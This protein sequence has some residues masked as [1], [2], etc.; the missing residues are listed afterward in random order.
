[1][2]EKNFNLTSIIK[3][4][5]VLTSGVFLAQALQV[6][7]LPL[8]TRLFSASDFAQVAV[9]SSILTLGSMIAT[10]RYHAAIPLPEH[11]EE[12]DSLLLL[13]FCLTIFVVGISFL[14][15]FFLWSLL[16]ATLPLPTHIMWSLLPLAIVL[17]SVFESLQIFLTRVNKYKKIATTKVVRV[18]VCIFVQ[19]TL[20]YFTLTDHGLILGIFAMHLAGALCLTWHYL[21]NRQEKQAHL[22]VQL[23]DLRRIGEK[24]IKYPKY[25]LPETF[26]NYGAVEIGIILIAISTTGP[27]AGY[28]YLVMRVLGIPMMLIGS[29]LSHA[30][31]A[32]A[33]KI[34]DGSELTQVTLRMMSFLALVGL[35]IAI[36]LMLQAP[37]LF[38]F[39]FGPE[40]RDAGK[41]ARWCV[42]W[43]FFQLISSPVS[44]IFHVIGKLGTA[45]IIQA[46]GFFIRLAFLVVGVFLF[47]DYV[48]YIFGVANAIF[49][50]ALIFLIL[51]TLKGLE[52]TD[53]GKAWFDMER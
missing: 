36:I 4:G 45:L 46:L 14:L 15:A 5:F 43:Y 48:I 32:K 9:F 12:A 52:D 50:C 42:V 18:A 51:K 22:D 28:L 2:K 33:A 53:A 8:L 6:I 37:M 7:S 31:Y 17:A 41:I 23:S 34:R 1:M 49:Y 29:S 26:F 27:D 16:D 24:F 39:A 38:A 10:L 21:V 11:T 40:W 30:Y 13:S 35:P 19:I 47:K 25:S 44:M 3:A 20:G